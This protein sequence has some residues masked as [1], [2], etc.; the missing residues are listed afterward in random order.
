MANPGDIS[1]DPELARRLHRAL[2]AE[3][4][5]LY[6]V[7]LDPAPEVLRS[8]LKNRNLNEDHLLALLKRRDLGEDLL[9]AIYQ[10]EQKNPSRQLKMALVHNPATPGPIVLSLLPHLY[11][12][13]L[14]DVCFLPGVTPDQKI[15]AERTIIQRLP[16]IE[17]GNK[18]TLAR[19]ATADVVGAILR[20]GDSR[21]VSAC[22]DNP[23]LKEV[24]ILQ[25]L[26]SAAARAD[27]IS[28]VAR[29]QKWQ[30]RP[31][32]RQT[33]LRNRKTPL[34]WFTLFLPKMRTP[35]LKNLLASRR[36][37]PQQKKL[38]QEELQRRG[39]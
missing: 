26:N 33:I 28:A 9:K 23:R 34:V 36:L 1:L 4:E 25:F 27:T 20:E 12:F 37:N 32:L 24:A 2:T 5:E 6:Q 39:L 35:E 7:V 30:N 3:S 22:L 38:L 11:L 16:Q 8:A 31:N 21:L 29:H 18:M 13:E 15:A 10:H 19:R 14:V 17:L